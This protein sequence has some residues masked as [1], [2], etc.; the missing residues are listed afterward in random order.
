MNAT[1]FCQRLAASFPALT[2]LR[3]REDIIPYSF[4]GTATY[5]Q[6]PAAVVFPTT[7]GDVAALLRFAGEMQV[8]VVT[9]GAGTGLSAGSLPVVGR[10]R[11]LPDVKMNRIK[12]GGPRA[13]SRCLAEAG[14]STQEVALAAA[15]ADLFYPPDPGSM[16]SFHHRRQRGGKLR[17]AARPEI[18]RST[19]DYVMGLEVVL[20]SGEVMWTGNK[21]VKDVAGYTLRDLF[22]GSE[23]TLGVITTVLLKLIPRPAARRTLLAIFDRMEDAGGNGVV[24]H[25]RADHPLHAGIP[26]WGDD[27]LRGG[28]RARRPAARRRRRPADGDGRPPCGGRGR[29]CEA[30]ADLARR[31]GAREVRA[32]RRRTRRRTRSPPHAARRRSRPWRGVAPTTILE[33]ATVPRSELGAHDPLHPPNRRQIPLEDRHLRPHGVMGICTP[34]S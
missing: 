17:R 14:A 8:P 10:A 33:D 34:P 32:R 20:A 29:G 13:T 9:R 22:I 23:G 16:E 11:A 30:M 3:E 15:A 2:C 1:E 27:Q 21:C 31:H 7:T 6:M 28:L 12:R 18:R 24:G 19:R 26:G 25:R 4:D 5:R